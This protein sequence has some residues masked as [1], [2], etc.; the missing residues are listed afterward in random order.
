MMVGFWNDT[1]ETFRVMP[2]GW[3]HTG[4]LAQTDGEG[5]LW[6]VGR[7]KDQINLGGPK[8]APA[9]VEAALASHP[10][11]EQAVVVGAPAEVGQV[12]FAFLTLCPGAI[13]PPEVDLRL[14]LADRLDAQSIPD[15]FVV[16]KDWPQTYHGKLDRDRL[17]LIAANDGVVV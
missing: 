6:F 13:C 1:S 10:A 2:E 12:P 15:R 5:R 14:W 17:R 3:L 9:M 7:C 4:D 11:V 16:L 8:V